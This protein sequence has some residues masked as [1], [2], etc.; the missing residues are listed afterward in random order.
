MSGHKPRKN[1]RHLTNASVSHQATQQS[2]S[3]LLLWADADETVMRRSSMVHRFS[4]PQC[5][6]LCNLDFFLTLNWQGPH[7][8]DHYTFW[9]IGRKPLAPP[10]SRSLDTELTSAQWAEN[11][12]TK[13]EVTLER[14]ALLVASQ[15]KV[16]ARNFSNI[17][18]INMDLRLRPSSRSP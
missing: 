1:Q 4:L 5:N 16:A 18:S 13:H 11:S 7:E 14:L 9:S 10:A 3:R 12:T 2:P 6:V 15:D 8:R 17:L